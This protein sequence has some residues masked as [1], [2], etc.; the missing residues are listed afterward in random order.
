MCAFAHKI[1]EEEKKL[2]AKWLKNGN[3]SNKNLVNADLSESIHI[4]TTFKQVP[5]KSRTTNAYLYIYIT[6][7]CIANQ[8]CELRTCKTCL[9]VE[10]KNRAIA[11]TLALCYISIERAAN[12]HQNG[13]M[14]TEQIM[15]INHF[16]I[17]CQNIDADM[18][19]DNTNYK[20]KTEQVS[21]RVNKKQP[22]RQAIANT[23]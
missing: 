10:E 7:K 4:Y 16:C 6:L 3:N 20:K 1:G 5:W 12:E 2:Q 8:N 23:M 14:F 21:T 18:V 19:Y 11:N 9:V 17:W 22:S 15:N 13:Q